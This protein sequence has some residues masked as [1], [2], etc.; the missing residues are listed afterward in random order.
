MR[1]NRPSFGCAN[2]RETVAAETAGK[3]YPAKLN[4]E[5]GDGGDD[6]S[7]RDLAQG[8]RATTPLATAA[9]SRS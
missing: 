7:E 4:P 2:R 8:K 9:S 1:E 6:G 5:I 3:I